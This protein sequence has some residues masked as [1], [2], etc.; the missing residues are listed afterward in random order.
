MVEISQEV[1]KRYQTALYNQLTGCN[2]LMNSF[3]QEC[4]FE[5]STFQKMY[6]RRTSIKET[7][8]AMEYLGQP[9]YWFTLTFNDKRDSATVK[10]KRKA[11]M[12]FLND[13]AASW[14]LVE[15]FG[16]LNSRYHIHG[17]LVFKFGKGFEDFR[18]WKSRQ[19]IV[20]LE[21]SK[22][23]SKRVYYLTNYMCKEVPRIRR[24]KSTITLVANYKKIKGL[25]RHGFNSL[26]SESMNSV[27]DNLTDLF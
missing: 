12:T 6:R 20:L 5:Y 17:F 7:I 22:K 3:R 26:C 11:A 10:S 8:S 19:N 23:V 14:V 27:I 15:E 4:P 16:E 24:S 9:M 18:E 13:L 25:E 1:F 21:N 2:D